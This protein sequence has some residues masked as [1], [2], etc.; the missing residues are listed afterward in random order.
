MCPNYILKF[1]HSFGY[2]FGYISAMTRSKCF[3]WAIAPGIR[4]QVY[5]WPAANEILAAAAPPGTQPTTVS[6]TNWPPSWL[7][8]HP[9]FK[10][11]LEKSIELERQH[12]MNAENIREF[13]DKYKTSVVDEHNIRADD[14]W[15][16]DDHDS[17]KG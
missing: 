6:H 3:G 17:L 2:V 9:G 16:M 10:V 12:A 8:R 15:N 11:A 13:F 7:R 1:K 14:I 4:V 5:R